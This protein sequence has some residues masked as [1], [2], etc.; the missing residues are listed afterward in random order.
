MLFFAANNDNNLHTMTSI[1]IHMRIIAI[2]MCNDLIVLTQGIH[3]AVS[4]R[5]LSFVI[6]VTQD[7]EG[8]T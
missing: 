1:H 3:G 7:M 8:T 2:Y 6:T 5:K 4:T